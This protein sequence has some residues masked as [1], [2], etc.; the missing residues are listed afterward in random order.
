MNTLII[1]TGILSDANVYISSTNGFKDE[2]FVSGG[3]YTY[4]NGSSSRVDEFITNTFVNPNLSSL[5]KES[6]VL[7]GGARVRGQLGDW[8]TIFRSL[9]ANTAPYDLSD[10]DAV[11]ITIHGY[12]KVQLRLEQDG[13]KNF[14]FH[15]KQLTLDGSEQTITIPFNE[16]K[17]MSGNSKLDPRLIRKIS[18]MILKTDNPSMTNVD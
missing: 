1:N 10:Y 4:L 15:I 13:I 12:G 6:M 8:I 17:Q 16:F 5:P 7:S 2:I 11:R 9:T 14:D 18:L 3:A